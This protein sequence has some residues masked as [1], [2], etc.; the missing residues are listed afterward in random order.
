M[1]ERRPPYAVASS[2]LIYPV[3]ATKDATKDATNT[4]DANWSGTKDAAGPNRD[5]DMLVNSEATTARSR[6]DARTLF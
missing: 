1:T 5:R 4:A 3:D 2:V 6:S